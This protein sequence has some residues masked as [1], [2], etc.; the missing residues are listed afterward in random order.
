MQLPLIMETLCSISK[1]YFLHFAH[2]NSMRFY[3]K[4]CDC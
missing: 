2:A 3:S 1:N 4:A